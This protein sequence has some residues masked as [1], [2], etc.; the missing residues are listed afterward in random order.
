MERSTVLRIGLAL[1]LLGILAGM[2]GGG[3]FFVL[4]LSDKVSAEVSL[5]GAAKIVLIGS[6]MVVLGVR[7]HHCTLN[8]LPKANDNLVRRAE[9]RLDIFSRAGLFT[10]L[11]FCI[12]LFSP[13]VTVSTNL[14]NFWDVVKVV[15]LT[16][17]LLVAAA[18]VCYRRLRG[19]R[20]DPEA[21]QIHKLATEQLA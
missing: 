10:L 7:L 3:T 15:V 16:I 20:A 14:S 6:V 5:R 11:L 12:L 18:V 8:H 4:F 1:F 9:R 13:L 2:F 21:M 19:A 17:S